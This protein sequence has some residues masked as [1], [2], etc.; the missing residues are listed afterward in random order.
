MSIVGLD[1]AT[2]TTESVDEGRRY[3]L[4]YGLVE[5][6]ADG[7]H[8]LFLAQ[9]NTGLRVAPVDTADLPPAVATG[10]NV[11]EIVWGVS[12]LAA[13]EHLAQDLAHDREVRWDGSL[14]RTTDIDG[15]SLTF[16]VTRR[17]PLSAHPSLVNVPG[18]VP[19][20]AVNS[21]QDF[22]SPILPLTFSHLVMYTPDLERI[23]ADYTNRLGFRITDRFT[24]AGAFMRAGVLSPAEN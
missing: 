20:R 18:M 14:L 24:N 16:R 22:S 2:L 19:Q 13:L 7:G 5:A 15:N 3:L 6:P 1:E 8:P 4:D 23:L 10:P 17:K 11:R 21:V 9:D 12:D